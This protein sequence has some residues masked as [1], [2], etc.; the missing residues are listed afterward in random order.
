[1][2]FWLLTQA[3]QLEQQ[4]SAAA[5]E[6][7]RLAQRAAE[8]EAELAAVRNA[9]QADL[10]DEVARVSVRLE[11]ARSSAAEVS[12]ASAVREVCLCGWKKAQQTS[13]AADVNLLL[14]SVLLQGS[15]WPT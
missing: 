1:M 7:H 12:V 10:A 13:Q 15:A 11:E 2:V 4:L 5:E 9:A 8:L 3:G 6:R 14:A